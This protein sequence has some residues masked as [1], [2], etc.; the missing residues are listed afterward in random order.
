M[1][2]GE[3]I[4]ETLGTVDPD[5]FIDCVHEPELAAVDRASGQDKYGG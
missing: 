1:G 3:N 5:R 2:S 4:A